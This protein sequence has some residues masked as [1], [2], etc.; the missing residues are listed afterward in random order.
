MK[1]HKGSSRRAR[2]LDVSELYG[3]GEKR[4][5]G[6]SNT[7]KQSNT[8]SAF[9]EE[10]HSYVHDAIYQTPDSD[11][12]GVYKEEN[13][14]HKPKRRRRKRRAKTKRLVAFPAV[15]SSF[16]VHSYRHSKLLGMYNDTEAAKMNTAIGL[17][18]PNRD[19][20]SNSPD[21]QHD[22]HQ[23]PMPEVVRYSD[24]FFFQQK[25]SCGRLWDALSSM[26]RPKRRLSTF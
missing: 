23:S 15:A 20:A 1:A 9:A 17:P 13:L 2:A 6:R 26:M 7:P 3:Q 4:L 11:P 19:Y 24:T 12:W 22:P 18:E 16:H 14:S 21:Q 25:T 8:S 5:S 10:L